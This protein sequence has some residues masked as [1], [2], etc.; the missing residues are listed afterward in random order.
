MNNELKTKISFEIL[1][2]DKLLN[3]SQP[4][5]DLCRIKIPDFIELSAAAMVLHSFYNGIENILLMI[6][7][8]YE[9][10]LPNGNNWHMELL[11][12]ATVQ[13]G[14]RKI[15]FNSELKN[16]LEEYR[17]FRHI[18]RHTYNYKLNWTMMEGIMNNVNIIWG[19]IKE[20]LNKFIKPEEENEI[21]KPHVV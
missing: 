2:I 5:Q 20:S 1:Q 19:K 18:V 12:K 3:E 11:E 13:Y 6:F 15:V 16:Q 10:K 14:N 17:K 7:K 8:N 4:L 9:E 21:E